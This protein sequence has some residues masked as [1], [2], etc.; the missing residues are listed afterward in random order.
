MTRLV[1]RSRTMPPSAVETG[2]KPVPVDRK[3]FNAAAV[4][5]YGLTVEHVAEAM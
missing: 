3:K 2:C 1:P 5:P 4:L